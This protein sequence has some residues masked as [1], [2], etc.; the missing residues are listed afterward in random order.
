MDATAFWQVIGNYNHATL[1]I[2]IGLLI[3]LV[4]S[5]VISVFTDKRNIC[6]VVLGIINIYIA[7]AFFMF[8][9]TQPIQHFFAFPLFLGIGL[10]FL[11]EGIIK[12]ANDLR[13]PGIAAMGLMGLYILYPVVSLLFGAQ[14]PQMVTH[15]MPC[16][17]ATVSI[18]VYSCYKRKNKILLL[19][20]TIWG[21]TGV[22]SVIFTVYEDIILLLAGIYGVILLIEEMKKQA[23]STN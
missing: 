16:P 22:K 12:R 2:Q 3:M 6:M 17:V 10:L 5:I 11:Y 19:F 7:I 4:A 9:G 8:F 20:L 13:K 1:A 21:L 23:K 14:F 15:I 18:A